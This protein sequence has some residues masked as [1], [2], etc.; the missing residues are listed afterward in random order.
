MTRFIGTHRFEQAGHFPQT[1]R[2]PCSLVTAPL[3]NNSQFGPQ[4]KFAAERG[5]IPIPDVHSELT[6]CHPAEVLFAGEKPFPSC[7]PVDHHAGSEKLMKKACN[8]SRTRPIFDI[9]PVIAKTAPGPARERGARRNSRGGHPLRRQPLFS[10]W[11]PASTTSPIPYWRRDKSLRPGGAAAR[12]FLTFP[13]PLQRRRRTHPDRA[14]VGNAGW[15]HAIDGASR[16]MYS[17]KPTGRCAEVWEIAA[18]PGVES[19]DFGLMDFVSGHHGAIPAAPAKSPSQFDH[20]GGP[21]RRKSPPPPWPTASFRPT[22]SPPG[23][24]ST[25]SATTPARPAANSAICACGHPSQPDRSHRRGHASGFLWKLQS[26]GEILTAAQDND[27]GPIPA[28]RQAAR[29]GYRYYW[30]LLKRAQVTGMELPAGLAA[31]FFP[32]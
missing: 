32:A 4:K 5:R 24:T 3:A 27:W 13:K 30:E 12:L 15:D 28:R 31:R 25:P 2:P 23:G 14:C 7:P 20:P 16:S 10:G 22:T 19:L 11:A 1:C 21:C 18:Q 17:S 8:S 9:T 6:M 26:A 29:P